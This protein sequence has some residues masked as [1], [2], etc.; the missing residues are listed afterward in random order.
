MTKTIIII[1]AVC[2]AIAF[3]LSLKSTNPRKYRRY[4]YAAAFAVLLLIGLH[5]PPGEDFVFYLENNNS[6]EMDADSGQSEQQEYAP[7]YSVYADYVDWS[8]YSQ[9]TPEV[10]DATSYLQA[11]SMD[12]VPG[13]A[14]DGNLATCWQ[15]GVEGYGE[16]QDFFAKFA[17]EFTPQYILIYNGQCTDEERYN[18]N[19]R[20][21]TLQISAN[22]YVE[23]V[24]I[25]DEMTPIAIKLNGWEA[26]SGISFK[27]LSV[28]EGS[29]YQDTCLTELMFYQ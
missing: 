11:E 26:V 27:I 21:A 8:Q 14:V 13:L 9:V 10:V 15:E 4:A 16:G 29:K 3:F 6:N 5:L 22:D 7:A 23:V 28:Y 18:K 2:F 17:T 20:I 25:P 24:A 1:G 12:Y 19:G